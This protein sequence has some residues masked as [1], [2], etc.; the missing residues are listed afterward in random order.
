MLFMTTANRGQSAAS[1]RIS[2]SS[3]VAQT[4]TAQQ[5]TPASL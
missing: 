2:T 5:Q 3:Q 1:Q 4:I